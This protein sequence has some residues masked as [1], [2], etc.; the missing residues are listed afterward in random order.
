MTKIK[1]EYVRVESSLVSS[2]R[3]TYASQKL[4]VFYKSGA[5][6]EY[7]YVKPKTIKKIR[8]AKSIGKAFHKYIFNNPNF[9]RLS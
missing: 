2:M 9:K 8:K 3:Y 4:L 6:Y 7:H 1:S 5:L